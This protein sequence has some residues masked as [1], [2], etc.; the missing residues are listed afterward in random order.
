MTSK[1]THV[2][3][4]IAE[5]LKNNANN[6]YK[7]LN[8]GTSDSPSSW[9]EKL[10]EYYRFYNGQK[11]NS[12]FLFPEDGNWLSVK[13]VQ[14]AREIW[15]DYSEKY[16]FE[17]YKESYFP[18]VAYLDQME[19]A[20]VVDIET[21]QIGSVDIELQEFHLLFEDVDGLFSN[22][23][24]TLRNEG[25]PADIEYKNYTE[26]ELDQIEQQRA[27]R[28]EK[29]NHQIDENPCSQL[30]FAWAIKIFRNEG[31]PQHSKPNLHFM[32]LAKK[33]FD[34]IPSAHLSKKQAQELAFF[35]HRYLQMKKNAQPYAPGDAPQASRP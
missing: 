21:G 7:S 14:M 25:Y 29:E 30:L 13:E 18:I 16:D 22:L 3:Q 19:N 33:Y 20:T 4:D 2:I 12:D 26:E 28:V 6:I 31:D 23:L 1:N 17:W 8:L 11:F 9:P 34:Q 15:L 27:L 24:H 10:R 35:N 32:R 5:W